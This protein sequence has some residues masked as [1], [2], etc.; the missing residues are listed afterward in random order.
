MPGTSSTSAKDPERRLAV[1]IGNEY[2]RDD[3][4]GI[5]LA[6]LARPEG[7]DVV[8][9]PGITPELAETLCEYDVV[10]FMDASVDGE[11]VELSRV[12]PGDTNL[13]LSHHVTCEGILALTEALYHRAP[14]AY[15]LSMRGYD[16]DHGEGLSRKARENLEQALERL[17]EF[18]RRLL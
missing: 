8:A 12:R 15:L 5:V 13:P 11:P 10:V 16:F 14:E 7:F 6:G 1:G 18:C 4:L 3:G 9:V 2:R 17:G